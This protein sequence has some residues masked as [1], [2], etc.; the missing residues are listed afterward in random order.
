[1]SSHFPVVDLTLDKCSFAQRQVHRTRSKNRERRLL[2]E[3]IL[4]TAGILQHSYNTALHELDATV[5][6]LSKKIDGL[7]N[8]CYD[9]QIHLQHMSDRVRESRDAPEK[10]DIALTWL[11]HGVQ[12]IHE[13]RQKQLVELLPDN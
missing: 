10:I 7:D 12:L 5:L 4:G 8:F 1:M 2:G 6:E 3:R 11:T 13:Y 9:Q